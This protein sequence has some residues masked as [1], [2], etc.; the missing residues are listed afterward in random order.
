[1]SRFSKREK[2]DSSIVFYPTTFD[3]IFKIIRSFKNKSSTGL[4]NMSSKLFKYFPDKIINCFVHI[5]NLSM[6]QGKFIENFKHAKVVPIHKG[7]DKY[8]K[9]N[10]RPVSLLAVASKILEK[11]IHKRLYS[12]LSSNGFFYEN[13]YGFRKN[14]STELATSFLINKICNAFE[15]NLKVMSV[16]LDMSKA[17][18]CVDHDI[19]LQKMNIYGIRGNALNWFKSYLSGRTQ[20]TVFNGTLS[21]NVY[22]LECGVPQGSILYMLMILYLV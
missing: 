3:E 8:E 13:Q 18:D 11:I 15:N 17:F 2:I 7:K 4:D 20:K 9:E 16:F 6:L 1:M 19:L 14:H 10:Y 22:S 5:F 21:T 12:F